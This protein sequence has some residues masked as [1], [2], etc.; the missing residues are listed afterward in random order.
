MLALWNILYIGDGRRLKLV[1]KGR[2]EGKKSDFCAIF[3]TDNFFLC[4]K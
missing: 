4:F 3:M 2:E 1:K